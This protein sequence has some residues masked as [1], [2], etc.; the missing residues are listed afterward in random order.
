[1]QNRLVDASSPYLRQHAGNPVHWQEWN[2]ATLAHAKAADTPILLSV[3]Y[4]AC[5]WCHVMAHESFENEAIAQAMNALFVNIKL[6]RE[7]RPDLDRVYQLAHQ[8]LSGR[9]G[10]WPLTVFL[11]PQDLTPFFAGTYFPPQPRHG[12]PGFGDLLQRVRAF[13]DTHRDELRK[14]NAELRG[15][16]SH[17]GQTATGEIPDPEAVA[18]ALQR[19]AGRFDPE[20]GGNAGAPKF[21][22]AS[23]LEL[24]IDCAIEPLPAYR[25]RERQGTQRSAVMPEDCAAMVML[26]ARNMATR[27]LQDHLGGGFFRYCV[28]ARWTIPHFEKMLY[29]N[30]QLLPLY[31]RAA[32]AFDDVGCEQAAGG[33]VEWL[34]R[35]MDSGAGTFF[36]ALDADSEGAAGR[37]DE[38]AFYVWTREQ[39]R[40][41]LDDREFAVAEAAYGLDGLPNFEGKAWHLLKAKPLELIV[42]QLDD[43]PE[44]VQRH[45]DSARKKLFAA[46]ARRVR[47]GTD[48]KVLTSWNA[49]AISA[50]ARGARALQRPEWIEVADKA[51]A[52]LREGA[53]IDNALY[54]NVAGERARIPGFLDDHAFLLDALLELL[55]CRWRDQ[56][57]RWATALAN[58]LLEKFED[59]QGGFRFSTAG[60]ATPLQN[61][62]TFPDEAL[63]SGNGV[64]ALTLLRFGHL[65]GETRYLES[66]ER[67]LRAGSELL[68][69]H[70]D[71]CPT[72]LRALR[73]FHAPRI[74]VVIRGDD[75][76]DAWRAAV[77]E[78]NAAR[79]D[80]F[81]IPAK[82]ATL[83]G[84]LGQRAPS[85]NGIAY[86][87]TGMSCRAPIPSPPELAAVL[88]DLSE[89]DRP[90]G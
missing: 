21:P 18:T 58:A 19:I 3:G 59:E 53:W 14:Q 28:D 51:L 67:C 41:V 29:D 13:Y 39:L 50:L 81:L 74:Q 31:A 90:V 46:R 62:R 54:A 15:W 83:P 37:L 85:G 24:L 32:A 76:Q 11:D 17:A 70:P 20:N 40:E 61:P 26:T 72:L 10:G 69:K 16:M 44:S 57:L 8:A 12:L 42:R 86:V 23:E 52:G 88:H 64:A 49:L 75:G 89:H 9:G 7:E 30:A 82:A 22:H 5:H 71:A 43:T 87:C 6:D 68:S 33:I 27:G 84:A 78:A 1:M 45:L 25:E 77:R 2:E 66:A 73:E 55:Q 60:H 4:S 80:A 47:P 38:G 35:E 56:D 79:M 48:D 65:L 63:P 36:S 34:Q